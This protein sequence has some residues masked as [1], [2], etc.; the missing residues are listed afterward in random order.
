MSPTPERSPSRTRPVR[1]C[2]IRS[3]LHQRGPGHAHTR[4]TVP[5]PC[6]CSCSLPHTN[7]C[8]L[9]Y[10]CRHTRHTP[11]ICTHAG[12][13]TTHI[14]THVHAQHP[15]Q[16]KHACTHVHTQHTN[17]CQCTAP[18]TWSTHLYTYHTPQTCTHYNTHNIHI[19]P[20]CIHTG[21][22]TCTTNMHTQVHVPQ[23]T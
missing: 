9:G 15:T 3:R 6:S 21:L 16:H 19:P 13:H 5:L 22:C 1:G 8:T 18:H 2:R 12:A 23:H 14:T 11:Q 7:T 17:T 4:V 20:M 10:V